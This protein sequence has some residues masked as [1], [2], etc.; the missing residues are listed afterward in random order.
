MTIDPAQVKTITEGSTL[1]TKASFSDP[2]RV[3]LTRRS[4]DWGFGAPTTGS[5]SDNDGPPR[6][7]AP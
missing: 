2:G 7:R 4:I 3:T 6:I 1:A 5:L